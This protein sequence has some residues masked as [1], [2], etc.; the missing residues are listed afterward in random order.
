MRYEGIE[1]WYEQWDELIEHI[2][3][4]LASGFSGARTRTDG[5]QREKLEFTDFA[6]M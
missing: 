6:G 5:T 4:S 3:V 2:E 1:E